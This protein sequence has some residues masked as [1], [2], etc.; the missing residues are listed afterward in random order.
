MAP[1]IE[2]ELT[3]PERIDGILGRLVRWS[4]HVDRR[5]AGSEGDPVPDQP[6]ATVAVG[7]VASMWAT[8]KF[9][10]IALTTP[11]WSPAIAVRAIMNQRRSRRVTAAYPDVVSDV[12][13]GRTPTSTANRT[14]RVDAEIKMFV[15]SDLHRSISGRTDW[16]RRQG[17]KRLYDAM[18]EHYGA[19]SWHLCENGD[20]EDFWHIGG[21][22]YGA[23]YDVARVAAGLLEVLGRPRLITSLY[24][25]HLDRVI[26][27]NRPSYDL[28]TSKFARAGRYHRTV[29]NHD[30]ALSRP[31]VMSRLREHIGPVDVVDHIALVDRDGSVRGY[32][33]HGHH[34][35]GWCAPGR[36]GLGRLST[37]L[38]DTLIDVPLLKTP[39]GLPPENAT[40]KLLSS[41]SNRLAT[42]NQMFGAN[43]SYDSLD[44]ELLFEAL[45]PALGDDMWILLGHTHIPVFEPWAR[46]GR[47]W[48]RYANSGCGV[49]REL[50]TGLEWDGTGAEAVMRL[51][52]W[53]YA[54]EHTPPDAIVTRDASG[55]EVARFEIRPGADGRL[56]PTPRRHLGSQL[57]PV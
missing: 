51:V 52:A 23:L 33:S 47:R 55:R 28:I 56:H 42:V 57:T 2:P 17:T 44:E 53:T 14:A 15:S 3:T 19:D 11:L 30:A 31:A 49:T 38:A 45:E 50:V 16:P 1:R 32:I 34:C 35:D 24:R 29:G 27:N 5:R 48:R 9:I 39:E 4:I 54:D 41:A 37:W 40:E 20:I 43:A 21:S 36:D 18:L 12:R 7:M 6:A 13:A 22:T 26:A 25:T 8:I 10:L 46:T